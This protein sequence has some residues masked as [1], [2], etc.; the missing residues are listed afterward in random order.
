[1]VPT[2]ITE[3]RDRKE[4]PKEP[5]WY[6]QNQQNPDDIRQR[7]TWQQETRPLVHPRSPF[8]FWEPTS[9]A[10]QRSY[11][12]LLSSSLGS[13]AL[14]RVNL[15]NPHDRGQWRQSVAFLWEPTRPKGNPR[16]VFCG[17]LW[18]NRRS[19]IGFSK[20]LLIEFFFVEAQFIY[21]LIF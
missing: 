2:K 10:N 16:S 9:W 15:Q 1:M 19:H 5:I 21:P 3:Q 11:W 8:D 14:P 20:V 13:S 17:F 4:T 18:A 6:L 7:R 12:L